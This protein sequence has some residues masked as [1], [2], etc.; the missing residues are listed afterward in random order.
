MNNYTYN[1]IIKKYGKDAQCD[2]MIEK[3]AELIAALNRFKRGRTGLKPVLEEIADVQIM[4]DQ[5]YILFDSFSIN[6]IKERKIQLM[7]KRLEEEK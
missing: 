2:M 6:Q 5:M 3:C 1:K 7:I 4:I